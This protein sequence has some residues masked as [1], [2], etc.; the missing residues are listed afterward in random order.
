[1]YIYSQ[2]LTL[3]YCLVK[4]IFLRIR[5]YNLFTSPVSYAIF[6]WC[7]PLPKKILNP[8]LQR[9][10]RLVTPFCLSRS[11]IIRSY[12]AGYLT[13]LTLCEDI[14]RL[15]VYS[16]NKRFFHCKGYKKKQNL[17]RIPL[18]STRISKN[19]L[20]VCQTTFTWSLETGLV[21]CRIALWNCF[22]ENGDIVYAQTWEVLTPKNP[23]EPP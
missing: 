10:L 5:C 20:P 9:N 1:M 7:T 13:N 6:L 21:L 12:S 23:I 18:F 3:C 19:F 15:S 2:Q 4:R 16:W 8:P 17:R 14:L 22:W 11:T